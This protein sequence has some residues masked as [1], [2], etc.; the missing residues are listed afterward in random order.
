MTALVVGAGCSRGC[1]AEE[2][3]AL[4]GA[5]LDEA[6]AQPGAVRALA[7]VDGRADE[8]G[9]VAAARHH[10]WPL[11]THPAPA[12]GAVAVPTPSAVVAAHVGTP[13]VAE[14]AAL[15]SAGA[16]ALLVP[17]RRSARATCALAE[18]G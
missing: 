18:S 6:G 2:L 7:T 5:V 17:K 9:M 3:L 13:S 11:V 1:P 14:A 8:P 15:L 10:G 4:I 12:L 16:G